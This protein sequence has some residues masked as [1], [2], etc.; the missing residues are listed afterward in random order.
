MQNH[1]LASLTRLSDTD[2]IAHV[3]ALVARE[4]DVTAELI[5]HLAELDSR[6]V[7]LREGYGSLYV[8]CRDALGLSEWEA[9]NRI[10]IA[11]AVRRFPAIL[12]MLAEGSL[13]LT[14]VRLLAPHLTAANHGEV[15]E[16]ARGRSKP[17]IQE[18][19]AR[20]SPRP[21][22][23]PSVRRLPAPQRVSTAS[24]VPLVA[25]SLPAADPSSAS[26]P[27]P[28]VHPLPVRPAA[29]EPLAPDRYRLQLTIGGETL[30]K[31]RLAK[32][33]LGHAI[34]AGDDAAILDR[35]LTVLLVDLAKKR[36]SDTQKPHRSQ[37]TKPRSALSFGQGAARRLGA[38]PRGAARSS[39]PAAI[40][41]TSAGSWSSTTWTRTSSAARRRSTRLSFGAGVTTTTRA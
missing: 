5:A 38:G 1:I 13:T 41:A 36:F 23:P 35:A 9:Y 16:R 22:V 26:L 33:M 34:P 29:V 15:L 37:G 25:S 19:V 30:E 4:R 18:L 2:L 27:D 11:R 12:D 10:E 6:D 8:Y 21:D 20:F 14:A 40:A 31:L 3:K 28:V 32:D 39:A 24:P 7:H 17:E